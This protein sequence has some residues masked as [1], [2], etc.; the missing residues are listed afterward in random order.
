MIWVASGCWGTDGLGQDANIPD[1]I[2]GITL[3]TITNKPI[4]PSPDTD[5][6]EVSEG[7]YWNNVRLR[8]PG[9]QNLKFDQPAVPVWLSL[10][11]YS[12]DD[13]AELIAAADKIKRI[14]A[15][16]LNL[17]CPNDHQ[18][19]L[20]SDQIKDL[21]RLTSRPIYVKGK[22]ISGG[23]GCILGNSINVGQGAI[24]GKFLRRLRMN[25]IRQARAD[26]YR[27]QIW[28]CGGLMGPDWSD[29]RQAGANGAQIGG[30]ARTRMIQAK[31]T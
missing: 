14:E 17:S 31:E 16:E 29:Y 5:F 12:L 26:G 19:D 7:L 6:V 10:R 13:W 15:Y 9:I 1:Y 11:G 24:S 2:D 18:S 22:L 28:A 20:V 25:E 30:F 4:R 8:N 23:Q 27:D 3:K 21:Q